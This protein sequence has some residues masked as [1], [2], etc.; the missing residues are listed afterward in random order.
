MLV[1]NNSDW[2]PIKMS[3]TYKYV[4]ICPSNNTLSK[5]G[6]GSCL[7]CILQSQNLFLT[8][9]GAPSL[10]RFK[11][12]LISN[13]WM[14]SKKVSKYNL[15]DKNKVTESAMLS[16]CGLWNLP[17]A[18]TNLWLESLTFPLNFRSVTVVDVMIGRLVYWF[19][20]TTI[21]LHQGY[22]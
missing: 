4:H 8:Q 3:T 18:F 14:M 10:Y 6:A 22:L 15:N 2:H 7:V 19:E 5:S 11:Q 21:I 12:C 16:L 20:K 9:F 13:N 17:T 1:T